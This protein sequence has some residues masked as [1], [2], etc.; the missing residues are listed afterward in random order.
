MS[1]QQAGWTL[2]EL[3]VIIVVLGILSAI[4]IPNYVDLSTKAKNAVRD[5]TKG[6]LVSAAALYIADHTGTRPTTTQLI[7]N[8][9][10]QQGVTLANGAAACQITIGGDNATAAS[11]YPIPANLCQ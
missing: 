3:V 5:G 7:N 10:V 2:I 8:T 4:A 6:A 1:K 11:N 9:I